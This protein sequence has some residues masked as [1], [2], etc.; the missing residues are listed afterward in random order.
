MEV[1]PGIIDAVDFST[2]YKYLLEN[3]ET[4]SR[5]RVWEDLRR[6]SPGSLNHAGGLTTGN[7]ILKLHVSTVLPKK[8]LITW[9]SFVMN[10]YVPM[11]FEKVV[12][13]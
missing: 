9:V 6:R 1:P 7:L 12:H 8:H 10:E 11:W 5:G 13:P 2:D 3:Y 4:V